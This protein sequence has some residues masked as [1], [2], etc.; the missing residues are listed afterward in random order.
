MTMQSLDLLAASRRERALYE[1][2]VATYH[3][4]GG[5]FAEGG[6][7]A[8]ATAVAALRERADGITGELRG[9]HDALGPERLAGAPVAA[10]VAACWRA[11]A[12]LAADAAVGCRTLVERARAQQAQV[13][14]RLRTLASGRRG[15]AGYRPA[16]DDRG[17]VAQQRA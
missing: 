5:L 14:T 12:A 10:E 15:L 11:S 6:P 17:V 16:A 9:L 2:L 3:E 13:T 8:D 7:L 1:A 4:L